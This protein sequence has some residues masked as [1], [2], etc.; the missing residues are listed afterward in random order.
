MRLSHRV[1]SVQEKGGGARED[2][3]LIRLRAIMVEETAVDCAKHVALRGGTLFS[4]F[5]GT[6]NSF[7]R[8]KSREAQRM[9]HFA[10]Q[11]SDL[12]E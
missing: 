2:Q 8:T 9:Q 4:K 12:G 3:A 6:I 11:C 5:L 10:S 7:A 1:R